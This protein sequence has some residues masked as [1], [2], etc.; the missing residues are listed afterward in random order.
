MCESSGTMRINGFEGRS[1]NQMTAFSGKMFLVGSC[2]Q[3]IWSFID[4]FFVS[5]GVILG[6]RDGCI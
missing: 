6:L 5:L 1:V 3:W 2:K 4:G